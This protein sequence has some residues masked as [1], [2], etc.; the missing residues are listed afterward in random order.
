[1][2]LW[3]VLKKVGQA[4]VPVVIAAA[5]PESV[6]NTTIGGVIKHGTPINNQSIPVINLVASTLFHYVP[7]ALESGDWVAPIIPALQQ[8]GV[9][10]GISTGLHQALKISAADN[11]TGSLTTK[12]GPGDK[13]SL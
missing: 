5:M 6:V 9:L 11:I 12:V 13:F 2:S 7:A 10:A 1:M 3:K 8:G 4:A